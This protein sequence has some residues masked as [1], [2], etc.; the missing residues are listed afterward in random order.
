MIYGYGVYEG[1]YR[2][3]EAAGQ[4]ADML[5]DNKL[6]NPR[7]RLD[8]GQ[9]VYGCECWWASEEEVLKRVKNYDNVKVVSIEDDR[10]QTR[11]SS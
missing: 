4:M 6:T 7:I 10:K 3:V 9:V 11:E 8:D 1:D 5:V 2:P